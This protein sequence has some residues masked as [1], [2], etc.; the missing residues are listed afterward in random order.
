MAR[1]QLSRER[2]G[3]TLAPTALVNEAFMKLAGRGGTEWSSRTHFLGIAARAMRQVLVDHARARVAE[4]RGG[5]W[6]RTTLAGNDPGFELPMEDLLVLDRALERLGELEQRLP[7]VVEMRF[8]GGMSDAE[9]ANELGVTER[10]VQRDWAKARA[11]L[12]K[13]IYRGRG[14]GG[15]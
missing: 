3:H 14:K 9:I 15:V 12:Y 4:K 6:H 13:E 2:A 10:T 5:D 8:F 7:R 1:V 11:W